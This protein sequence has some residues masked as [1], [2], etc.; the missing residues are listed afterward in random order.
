M[1]SCVWLDGH[2]ELGAEQVAAWRRPTLCPAGRHGSGA[3]AQPLR[4]TRRLPA[5]HRLVKLPLRARSR[6][7]APACTRRWP[8]NC[9]P[10]LRRTVPAEAVA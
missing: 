4:G 9:S 8:A 7:R 1:R 5:P 10:W 6:H 2:V 3:A